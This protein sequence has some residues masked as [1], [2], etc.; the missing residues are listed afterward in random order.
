MLLIALLWRSGNSFNEYRVGQPQDYIIGP[1]YCDFAI[2]HHNKEHFW[3]WDHLLV[4]AEIKE[5]K[6]LTKN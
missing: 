4:V 6:M 5:T 2:N 1:R 3:K